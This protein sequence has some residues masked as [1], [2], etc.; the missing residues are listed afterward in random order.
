MRDDGTRQH[1]VF[2]RNCLLIGET[3]ATCKNQTGIADES[4][5]SPGDSGG[6]E[7]IDGKIVSVTSFGISGGIFQ[8][9]GVVGDPY[10]FGYC[11]ADSSDPYNTSRTTA[12]RPI[13]QCT[14]SSVG[15]IGGNTLVSYNLDFIN[16]SLDG[17]APRIP[18]VPEPASWAMMMAGLGL[19]G[20]T[21]RRRR[22]SVAFA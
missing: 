2:G 5:A 11:G 10:R 20:G 18:A 13:G 15:E 17:S 14:N 12:K 8:G 4:S 3:A 1:D 21:M 19:G 22:T 16:A 6:P 7:F 9:T